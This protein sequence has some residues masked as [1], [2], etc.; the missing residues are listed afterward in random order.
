MK[1]YI[2]ILIAIVI[3]LSGVN[4]YLAKTSGSVNNQEALAIRSQPLPQPRL[5]VQEHLKPAEGISILVPVIVYHRIGYA[6]AK[7]GS[8]YKSLTIE[9]EW[10]EKHL[11]YLRDNGFHTVHFSDVADYFTTGKPLPKNPVMINFDDGYK[12]FYTNALPLLKKYNMTGTLFVVAGS[13]GYPAYVTWDQILEARDA[14]IEIG[15]HSM[16]HPYLTKSK[17]AAFEITQSKKVL[18]EKLGITVTAFAYPYGSY[19]TSIEQMVKD[20]GYTTGRSFT[21]GNGISLKNLF[22]IPVVRVYANVGL[23]RWKS[24]LFAN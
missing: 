7:A 15:A 17:K 1:K 21:T 20:S 16:T 18:E 5:A 4:L 3:I 12:D 2:G 9:P 13:V 23:E 22:H 10:F 19:N 6:P 8:V 24:Q 11:Q 14:G